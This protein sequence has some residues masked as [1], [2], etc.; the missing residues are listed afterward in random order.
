MLNLST[1][2]SKAPPKSSHSRRTSRAS[3]CMGSQVE[4]DRGCQIRAD[5]SHYFKLFFIPLFAILVPLS[6][7][8]Q[9][10]WILRSFLS[11]SLEPFPINSYSVR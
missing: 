2:C 5:N 6:L 4:V 3:R 11:F 9:M 10:W 8:S 1:H 7:G